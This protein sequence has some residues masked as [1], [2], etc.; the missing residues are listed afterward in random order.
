MQVFGVLPDL[1]VLHVV[2][3]RVAKT[4][5]KVGPDSFQGSIETGIKTIFDVLETDRMFG[6][7]VVIRVLTL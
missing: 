3:L 7:L 4:N 2:P 5:F 6:L 1:A